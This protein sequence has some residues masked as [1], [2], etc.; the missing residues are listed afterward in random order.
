MSVEATAD[1]CFVD[2]NVWLYILL[3][4]QDV[5]KSILAKEL[6][7]RQRANIVIST[8]VINEVVN[9]IIRHAVMSSRKYVNSSAGF[10]PAIKSKPLLSQFNC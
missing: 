10:M 2:S 8:Q 6:V 3:P 9:G 1:L 7:S 4:G 5:D